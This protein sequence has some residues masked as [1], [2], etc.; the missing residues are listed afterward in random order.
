MKKILVIGGS[1]YVGQ[2]LGL[3]IPNRYL[4]KT[5]CKNISNKNNSLFFDLCNSRL[6]DINIDFNKFSHVIIAAGMVR[7]DKILEQPKEARNINVNCTKRLIQEIVEKGLIPVFISSE[8]VFDGYSGNYNESDE[9]NPIHEYGWHKYSI[10][11]FIKKITNNYLIIRLSKVYD[12][13]VDGK[14]L[15]TDWLTKI[16]MNQDIVCAND[17]V[18]TPI[19]IDDVIVYIEKLI[20]I[21]AFGIFHATSIHPYTRDSM[22]EIVIE[23][24]NNYKDFNGKVVKQSLHSFKGAS[25]IPLNT[26]MNPSKIIKLTKIYPRSFEDWVDI[27]T[28]KFINDMESSNGKQR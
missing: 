20:K 19:H 11:K 13:F 28:T 27:I 18:F 1:G 5:Y 2:N 17:H 22:L 16:S 26:S 14:T 21:N 25:E 12:S 15:I 3:T 4:L 23:N 9:P 8:S 10:E 6:D 7:F 24:Y